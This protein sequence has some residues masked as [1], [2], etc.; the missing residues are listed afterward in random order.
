M[1][2]T[3][4]T[5]N[6]TQPKRVP[7]LVTGTRRPRRRRSPVRR[8]RVV[9]VLFILPAAAYVAIFHLFPLAYGLYLSFTTYDPQSRSGPQPA[10]IGNYT[11]ILTDPVFLSS[12]LVT[13]K[14]VLYVLPGAVILA[15]ILALMVNRGRRG[16]GFF[17]TA[18]YVPHVVSLTAVS[19]V[20]LWLYSEQGWFNQILRAAGIGE[21]Q[22]LLE[23]G[24]ALAA[25]AVMRIWKALGGNMVLLLAGLQS[26][27]RELF[28]AAAVDGAGGWAKFRYVTLPGLRG[29]LTYVVV[30]DIVYL[31]QSF[32]E[33]YILTRGGPVDS[34]TTV[35]Y[36]IYKQAFQFNDMG[37]ASA[38]GF[39]LFALIS[40]VSF[41]SL[42]QMTGRGGRR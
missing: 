20:W 14:Y 42:R 33:I 11:K 36:L 30:T 35:N 34:T 1:T 41:V 13:A 2:Q 16:V 6:I 4:P 38:M 15:L 26:I 37:T 22:F 29:M 39:V 12:L 18:L 17:R 19:M 40:A 32:G 10:G 25:V 7:E 5:T 24:T 27:P 31:A 21:R 23:S 28:E 3:A 9:G 8:I